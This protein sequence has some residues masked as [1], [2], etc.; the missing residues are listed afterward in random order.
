MTRIFSLLM[1]LFLSVAGACYG[2]PPTAADPWVAH[3]I[4]LAKL[5]KARFTACLAEPD[6]FLGCVDGVARL[7]DSWCQIYDSPDSKACLVLDDIVGAS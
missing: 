7:L 3:D 1:V 4:Q 2:P 5:G 6:R